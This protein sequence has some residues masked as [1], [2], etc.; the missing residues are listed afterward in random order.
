MAAG[1]LRAEPC[2]RGGLAHATR[3]PVAERAAVAAVRAT[4]RAL[5]TGRRAPAEAA[6]RELLLAGLSRPA[7]ALERLVARRER[8]AARRRAEAF[9]RRGIAAGTAGPAPA[10]TRPQPT[11][12]AGHRAPTRERPVH[13][14]RVA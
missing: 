8:S 7:G 3:F 14:D 6:D 9:R 5:L 11:S 13:G 2:R 4:V 12:R 1:V 10:G